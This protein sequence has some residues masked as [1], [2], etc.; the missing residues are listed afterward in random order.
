MRD[1]RLENTVII[2]RG[3]KHP[4]NIGSVARAMHNMGFGQ[5]RLAAPQC[6]LNE[7]SERL[8]R[9]GKGVL[10]SACVFRT[11]KS[12]TRDLRLL[13]GTTGKTGGKRTQTYNPR[14]LAG[15]ILEH[16]ASQKVGILFGPED[17][18]LVD[19]DLLPCQMLIRIPTNSSARSINLAQA[20]MIVCYELFLAHLERDPSEAEK[21]ATVEQVEAMY[22]Q[23]E[24]ALL[25]I[26]FLHPQNAQHMMFA[27]RRLLGRAGLGSEDVGVLRG[28]ARQ[29]TWYGKEHRASDVRPQKSD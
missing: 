28:I 16:A 21:L 2:L 29:I 10:D 22:A 24:A 7:E 3:T 26:G 14:V 4:G 19:E 20:V 8:A 17:T 5:L 25:E 23:L 15:K 6:S 13:V 18:G 12:A 11:V 27:L 9:A 1:I